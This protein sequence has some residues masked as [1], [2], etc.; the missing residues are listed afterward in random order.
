MD[1]LILAL[2]LPRSPT[3]DNFVVGR[4]AEAVAALRALAAGRG[5]HRLIYL[6]GDAGCGR[7]H[8]LQAAQAAAAQSLQVVDDVQLAGEAAQHEL[9]KVA[10]MTLEG[11][12]CLLVSAD[13]PPATLPLREDLRTR[14]AAGLVLRLSTLSDEDKREALQARALELGIA[15]S[16]EA[17]DYMLRHCPRDLKSLLAALEEL[18]RASLQRH[19]PVSLALL[20]QCLAIKT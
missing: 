11:S 10:L 15:L 1:Q 8:L 14:L 17:T 2:S 16:P 20:R 13:Q 7:T 6:W 3:F 9:F 19:R 4:N 5:A 12:G 18:D